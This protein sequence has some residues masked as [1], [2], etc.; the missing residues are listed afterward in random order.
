MKNSKVIKNTLTIK[1]RNPIIAALKNLQGNPGA[2]FHEKSRG[3]KRRE[4][5]ILL[6]KELGKLKVTK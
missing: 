3:A 2:G 6:A 4:E 5:K 1:P